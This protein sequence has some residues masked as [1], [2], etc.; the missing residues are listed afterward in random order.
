MEV[1]DAV[2]FINLKRMILSGKLSKKDENDFLNSMYKIQ[3]ENSD[4][5]SLSRDLLL[6]EDFLNF[7][8]ER[9]EF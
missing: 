1:F 7:K 6:V 2:T 5:Q 9:E 8:N 3:E 4:M